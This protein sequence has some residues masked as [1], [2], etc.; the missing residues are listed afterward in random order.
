MPFTNS[1]FICMFHRGSI[2]YQLHLAHSFAPALLISR[3]IVG[4]KF[5][6]NK[7][8]KNYRSVQYSEVGIEG[9]RSSLILQIHMRTRPRLTFPKD[10]SI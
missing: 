4:Y 2:H 10:F 3:L 5:Q 7:Y 9:L 6:L 8:M 1:K